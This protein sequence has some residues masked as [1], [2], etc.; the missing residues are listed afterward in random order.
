MGIIDAIKNKD[1]NALVKGIASICAV[2]PPELQISAVNYVYCYFR[3]E[4]TKVEKTEDSWEEL[5]KLICG[6][7]LFQVE[8]LNKKDFI[9][10]FIEEYKERPK[11]LLI[12]EV[13]NKYC[14]DI[15]VI[16]VEQ[17]RDTFN[18][19]I[20]IPNFKELIKENK[21][22]SEASSGAVNEEIICTNKQELVS[23]YPRTFENSFIGWKNEADARAYIKT[24]ILRHKNGIKYGVEEDHP[25]VIHTPNPDQYP[26]QYPSPEEIMEIMFL[27]EKGYDKFNKLIKSIFTELKSEAVSL[28]STYQQMFEGLQGSDLAK[29]YVDYTY[30]YV[31]LLL[32]DILRPPVISSQNSASNHSNSTNIEDEDIELSDIE[33]SNDLLGKLNGVNIA[34][35]N[36]IIDKISE[37]KKN[38]GKLTQGDFN[39][40]KEMQEHGYNAFRRDDSALWKNIKLKQKNSN[41]VNQFKEEMKKFLSRYIDYEY[42]GIGMRHISIGALVDAFYMKFYRSR[43]PTDEVKALVCRYSLIM[44]NDPMCS[45]LRATAYRKE[46]IYEMLKRL[47]S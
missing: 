15:N 5:K 21:T 7:S 23:I 19:L 16:T 37:M 24:I 4:K 31:I 2:L 22:L 38:I 8:D 45:N 14:K 33:L 47:Y 46:I 3:L 34:K 12:D 43:F 35:I 36:D 28:T 40:L 20:K 11:Y 41:A 42:E 39:K 44:N 29:I 30:N 17:L 6:F 13:L 1:N 25:R 10:H 27:E 32:T 26:S 9:E 18:E